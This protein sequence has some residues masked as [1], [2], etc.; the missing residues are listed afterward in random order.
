VNGVVAF[1]DG[2]LRIA[3]VSYHSIRAIATNGTVT[4]VA[5]LAGTSGTADGTGGAGGTARFSQPSVAGVDP[6]GNLLVSDSG[7]IR[8]VDSSG[9]VTTISGQTG[10]YGDTNGG[11]A[12]ATYRSPNNI[13]CAADGS[14]WIADTNNYQIRR[15]APDG[16]VTSLA[17]NSTQSLGSEDGQGE[18]ARFNLPDGIALDPAG[19]LYVSDRAN[20]T[21]RKI[22]PD[23][24]VTTLAGL[25]GQA[26]HVDATG[27]AARFN[28]P[29][30]LC[31]DPQGNI[32]V[33]ERTGND[34][35]KITPSG[36]VTTLASLS[37]AVDVVLNNDGNYFAAT[38]GS[39]IYRITPGGSVTTAAGTTGGSD[40]ES[41]PLMSNLSS[42]IGLAANGTGNAFFIGYSTSCQ[43]VLNPGVSVIPLGG[44]TT[45]YADGWGGGLFNMQVGVTADANG[46]CF[47]ADSNNNCIRKLTRRGLASTIGGTVGM[48]GNG[49][50]VGSAAKFNNPTSLVVAPDGTIYV[51]NKVSNN[52][53]KGVL[54][55]PGIEVYQMSATV[56]TSYLDSRD[57]RRFGVVAVGH[58]ETMCFSIRNRGAA[59]L[60][61]IKVT[62]DGINA[63]E[64]ALTSLP[65]DR[66]GAGIETSFVV[67]FAPVSA[68][69]KTAALHIAS[70]DPDEGVFDIDLLGTSVLAPA[71]G[72]LYWRNF[73]GIAGTSGSLCENADESKFTEP[74]QLAVGC[75]GD[76]FVADATNSTIVK[77][78]VTGQVSLVARFARVAGST[79][80]K[81]EDAQFVTPYAVACDDG[82]FLYISDKGGNRVRR[83]AAD[84]STTTLATGLSAPAG[85]AWDPSSASLV[86]AN[87]GSH[88][89]I[90]VTTAG[91][92]TTIAGTAGTS[93]DGTGMGA[94]AHFNAPSGIAVSPNGRVHVS[95]KS[96]CNIVESTS[97]VGDIAVD[98]VDG[99]ALV[100]GA[101][102]PMAA[103]P[104]TAVAISFR[105]RNLGAATLSA[106]SAAISGADGDEFGI[107]Q[108]PA[109]VIDPGAESLLTVEFHPQSAGNR[110]AILSIASNDPDQNPFTVN[111]LGGG[112]VPSPVL[113]T[114]AASGVTDTAATLHVTLN[115]QGLNATVAF[116]YGLPPGY[117]N[118]ITASP[119]QVSGTATTAVVAT[120]GGLSAGTTYHYRIAA[121]HAYGA[122]HGD[123][124]TFTTNSR[125]V[126]AGY[127]LATAYQTPVTAAAADLLV[128]ASDPDGDA[129][130]ITAAGP[131]SATGGS[132]TMQSAAI[133]Y[134]PPNGF[135]GNDSFPILLTDARGASATGTVTVRV[136]QT[137]GNGT[138]TAT[139]T[140]AGTIPVTV[141]AYDAS[142]LTAVLALGFAPPVGTNLT[143]VSNTGPSDPSAWS[144]APMARWPHGA[145]T[146]QGNWATTARQTAACRWP[147]TP[148]ESWQ[149]APWWLF[150][151]GVPMVWRC[152]RTAPWRPG[153]QTAVAGWATEPA[154]TARRPPL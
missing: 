36:V 17:G 32:I 23:G 3:D 15:L 79:D 66:L 134:T 75:N 29:R 141:P 88:T 7:T 116:D 145:P 51:A 13:T 119:A 39:Y 98:R 5:G 25:A 50:G 14:L 94:A 138:V 19:F 60:A 139:F 33:S 58:T 154:P 124:M 103:V 131:S 140:S 149:A 63:S 115:A 104:E 146:N 123:D 133:V 56:P 69:S 1:A 62:L 26:G 80:G 18:T 20:N 28:Y 72:V 153:E 16:Q 148:P 70:N 6:A 24:T 117:G 67:R 27:S 91:V 147:W 118:T 120:L 71:A 48:S 144:C 128:M 43:K 22:S 55:V 102:V 45:G 87:T 64:F 130:S 41:V 90:R 143:L 132:V 99:G 107:S 129:V 77:I 54:T 76:L 9:S 96:N 31:V 106:V 83:I 136:G 135:S 81:R 86:V 85:V 11:P 121:S 100:A 46:N 34:L 53:V 40:Y 61:E 114:L 125:P 37:N 57:H 2:S 108:M 68:G 44:G 151:R 10:I 92:V 47:V 4:T 59:D 101:A 95:N 150:R 137:P 152:A 30:G 127:A 89:L 65:P 109:T 52:I 84:G 112:V 122:S 74:R 8:R 12:A 110:S 78:S 126:F 105:I 73:A 38:M 113:A 21:V 97:L 111:L 49:V 142:G 35:R 82:G 93:G 42:P